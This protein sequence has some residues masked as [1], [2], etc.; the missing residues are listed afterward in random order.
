MFCYNISSSTSRPPTNISVFG[1]LLRR[2][3]SSGLP[4]ICKIRTRSSGSVMYMYHRHVTEWVFRYICEIYSLIVFFFIYFLIFYIQYCRGFRPKALHCYPYGKTMVSLKRYIFITINNR[5]FCYISFKTRHITLLND[6]THFTIGL[7]I[8]KP[9]FFKG[10]PI[11][12]TE[13]MFV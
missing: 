2:P 11:F 8:K 3:R 4:Y 9:Q 7:I 10:R 12:L 13:T 1:C 6:I 5:K